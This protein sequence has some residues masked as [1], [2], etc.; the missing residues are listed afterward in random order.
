LNFPL[1]GRKGLERKV[2]LNPSLRFIIQE[3]ILQKF[4]GINLRKA[5]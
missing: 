5:I 4:F 3:Q 1:F 2:I